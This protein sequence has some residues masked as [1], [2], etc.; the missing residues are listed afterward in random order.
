MFVYYFLSEYSDLFS[1]LDSLPL[2][3]MG[4]LETQVSIFTDFYNYFM[5]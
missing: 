4:V 2:N 1:Q 3:Y 5:P